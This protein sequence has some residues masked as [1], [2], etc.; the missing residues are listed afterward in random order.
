MQIETEIRKLREQN[1]M[2]VDTL[3]G[4]HLISQWVHQEVACIMLNIQPR[5]L[6]N[7]RIHLDAD[8]KRVGE[9][10]WKKGKGR[11]VLYYKPDIEKYLN[12]I[13][14]S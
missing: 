12:N 8:K 5:Q 4:R 3:I 6:R 13:V 9:I 1:K 7:V 11:Q 14:I 10:K 2:L